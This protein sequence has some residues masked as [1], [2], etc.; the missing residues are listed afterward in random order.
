MTLPCSEAESKRVHLPTTKRITPMSLQSQPTILYVDDDTDDCHILA[1]SF[2][3]TP[4]LPGLI[5]AGDGEAALGYL[6]SISGTALPSLI[7]LD[8][9]MPKL[10]GRQTLNHLKS[11]PHLA[12]IPVVILSTSSNRTDR[13]ACVKLGAASYFEKPY[14]YAGYKEI[15]KRCLPLMKAAFE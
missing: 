9:N 12:D 7:I 5:C 8:L 11:D 3:E 2:A 1:E 6:S 14:H 13:E 15:V 4:N 10:D